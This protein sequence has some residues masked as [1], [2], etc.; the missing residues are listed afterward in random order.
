MECLRRVDHVR[1]LCGGRL[2]SGSA[3][4]KYDECP[5]DGPVHAGVDQPSV[6]E[7]LRVDPDAAHPETL[8]AVRNQNPLCPIGVLVDPV[9]DEDVR[10]VWFRAF[11]NER[12]RV[13][14][15]LDLTLHHADCPRRRDSGCA[16]GHLV[17]VQPLQY[18][19]PLGSFL[20][21]VRSHFVCRL[22]GIVVLSGDDSVKSHGGGWRAG[23]LIL[24]HLLRV[25]RS[26][27]HD[28]VLRR[29]VERC[30]RSDRDFSATGED[31]NDGQ[32]QDQLIITEHDN[33][34]G[35]HLADLFPVV[36]SIDFRCSAVFYLLFYMISHL[37][38]K[39][40]CKVARCHL[41]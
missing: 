2:L 37:R 9:D 4:D 24:F 12:K 27:E 38:T 20:P 22:T 1:L 36:G 11:V 18:F 13:V 14:S 28:C 8:V 29:R 40:K 26:T 16:R 5:L 25:R 41:G 33:L 23:I 19:R 10:R 3:V 30:A 6:L 35:L 32:T 7:D 15:G 21:L 34:L 17:I 39:V 31:Q